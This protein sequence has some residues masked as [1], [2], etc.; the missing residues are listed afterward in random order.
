MTAMTRQHFT[1]IADV[2]SESY[3]VGGYPSGPD[4]DAMRR[5]YWEW[6]VRYFGE[7]LRETNPGFNPERF[8]DACRRV[9]EIDETS[10]ANYGEV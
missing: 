9:I 8:A 2:L 10:S 7:R 3:P 1:F 4:D 6:L 5:A